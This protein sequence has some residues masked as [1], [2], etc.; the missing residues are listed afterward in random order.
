MEF[1]PIAKGHSFSSNFN[2]TRDFI[3][4]SKNKWNSFCKMDYFFFLINVQSQHRIFWLQ[5][6]VCHFHFLV[7]IDTWEI[8]WVLGSNS[9]YKHDNLLYRKSVRILW[10]RLLVILPLS[11]ISCLTCLFFTFL[12][13]LEVYDIYIYFLMF[14][15]SNVW[16]C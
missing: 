2:F 8:I 4:F 16:L 9:S 5:L 12:A 7:L 14:Q 10:V 13:R 6:Q 11:W 3:A 1:F 15:C